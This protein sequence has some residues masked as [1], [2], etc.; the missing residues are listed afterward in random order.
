MKTKCDY[1]KGRTF[2]I[3]TNHFLCIRQA[4]ELNE[5]KIDKLYF[6]LEKLEKKRQKLLNDEWKEYSFRHS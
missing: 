1:C 4:T 3:P 6:Q 5:Y 2:D